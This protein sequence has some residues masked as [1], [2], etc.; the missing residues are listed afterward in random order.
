MFDKSFFCTG[1]G[2]TLSTTYTHTVFRAFRLTI[3]LS[4]YFFTMVK[5]NYDHF[6]FANTGQKLYSWREAA[7]R[8]VVKVAPF[9]V[10]A[11]I[12]LAVFCKI[13][14]AVKKRQLNGGRKMSSFC[15]SVCVCFFLLQ[16]LDGILTPYFLI[17]TR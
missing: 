9:L 17:G 15:V 7:A 3:C 6:R 4:F 1:D 11:K 14:H 8:K 10:H 16:Y 5:L 13:L 2:Q 12:Y